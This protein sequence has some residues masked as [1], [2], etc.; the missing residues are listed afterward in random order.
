M[1][2]PQD[3]VLV[4]G[5][6][7]SGTTVVGQLLSL[8]ERS[9][10]LY[11]PTNFHAGDRAVSDYFMV[12][13]TPAFPSA[14][15]KL[16]Y[17]RIFGLDLDLKDGIWPEETGVKRAA[18]RLLGGRTKNSYRVCKYTHLIKR[19]V[20]KDP[21]MLFALRYMLQQYPVPIIVT[22]RKIEGIAASF[23]RFGWGFDILR[24]MSDLS[25][26]RVIPNKAFDLDYSNPVTNAAAIYY[27]SQ[28]E[29]ST[30]APHAR[31][32]Q[33]DLDDLIDNP[34]DT[35]STLYAHCG[36]PFTERVAERV[37]KIYSNAGTKGYSD[38]K[39]HVKNRDVSQI[40]TYWSKFLTDEDM[41]NIKRIEEAFE[42]S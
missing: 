28:L 27:L 11:E 7:R 14:E 19:I 26:S 13:D 36:F 24:L 4:S 20:W 42:C 34:L 8:S 23:K 6:P 37:R 30:L 38:K 5:P 22:H 25:H 17:D 1:T 21:F 33:V 35:V 40:K 32:I 12:P 39:A 15:A 2:D 41:Y 10:Y 29:L 16:L 18:K 31:L 9:F 3:F